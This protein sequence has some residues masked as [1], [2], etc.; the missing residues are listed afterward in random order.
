MKRRTWLLGA[1]GA[2]GAMVVGWGVLPQR[3]RTGSRRLWPPAEGEVAFS[4]WIKILRDG[5]VVLAMPQSEM[6]QGVH[7]ALAMLAAG[8]LRYSQPANGACGHP[9]RSASGVLALGG[10]F[11][12]CFFSESSVDE[13]AFELKQDPLSLRRQL[14][15]RAPR[16]PGRAGAG[17]QP[18]WVGRPPAARAGRG[19]CTA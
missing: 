9:Q 2:A 15:A 11:T 7:T 16:Y 12:Q 10:A 17:G 8:A 6:G 14:L 4:V 5:A 1:A 3:S 19:Y 18:G 13:I